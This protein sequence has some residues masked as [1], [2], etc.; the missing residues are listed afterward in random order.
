[1]Q[2]FRL[3]LISAFIFSCPLV[4]DE[5]MPDIFSD[6]EYF[7][8]FFDTLAEEKIVDSEIGSRTCDPETTN[9]VREKR[10]HEEEKPSPCLNH[11]HR[12]LGDHRLTLL[13]KI[14]S[15]VLGLE[16][17]S[18]WDIL[19]KDAVRMQNWKTGDLLVISPHYSWFG[20][21]SYDVTNQTAASSVR[22]DLRSGSTPYGTDSHWVVYLDFKRG[23]VT[24]EDGSIWCVS[25]SDATLFLNW[26]I[27]DHII[28]GRYHT[29]FSP[30]D[31]I[32][33]NVQMN[34]HV[35]AERY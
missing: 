10:L 20:S 18:Q 35:R 1:M 31:H 19:P 23:H 5:A 17:G 7:D 11:P 22:A 21:G 30:Y 12:G 33:I 2:S 6:L 14:D 25:S 28:L 13:Q 8:A 3:V 27:N 9:L 26:E 24:L 4:A 16:D 32:L 29:R 34:A 15:P